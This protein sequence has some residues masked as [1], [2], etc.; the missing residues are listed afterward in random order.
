MNDAASSAAGGGIVPAL[1]VRELVAGYG[2]MRVIDGIG[3]SVAPGERVGIVGLNGHG[4]TTLLRAIVG[5]I[6]WRSGDVE[7]DGRSILRTP[8][9]RLAR[10]GLVFVPQGDAL[11]PG[12]TVQ[13]NLDVGAYAPSAW[14]VRGARRDRVLEIFPRLRDRLRQPVGTLSGGERRMV[15]LGRGLMAG[16]RVYLVD[17]PSLGLAP[18]IGTGIVETLTSLDLG[19][20]ALLIVEQNRTL[21]D[22]RVDRIVRIHGGRIVPD[23]PGGP[24]V[25][26]DEAPMAR[27]AIA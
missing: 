22:G 3:L 20:G 16:G 13:E 11:F 8:I 14:R 5:L 10:V 7:L 1:E 6:D 25:P 19:G 18:G 2:P 24:E 9:H 12:L 21:I 23:R 26:P 27:E 4:K 15:S 17:E